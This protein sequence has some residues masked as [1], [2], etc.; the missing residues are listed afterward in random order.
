VKKLIAIVLGCIAASAVYADVGP[1]PGF[2]LIPVTTIVETT[3]DFSDYAFFSI[4]FSTRA[5]LPHAGG[6]KANASHTPSITLHFIPPGTLIKDTGTRRSGSNLYI[7]P[8]S[9]VIERIPGWVRDRAEAAKNSPL[10]PWSTSADDERWFE[11]ARAVRGGEIPGAISV[12]FGST[13][14]VASH[15]PRTEVTIHYRAV[16]GRS[17]ELTLATDADDEIF[18]RA[19]AIPWS[20][21]ISGISV[22]LA[23]ILAGLWLFRRYRRSC[24]IT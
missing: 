15:D 18:S 23:I 4:D 16:R 14:E 6:G 19:D 2:K 3:D 8:A 5:P 22:S 24:T 7:L 17:G 20:W 12:R 9:A 11:L 21:L 13:E 10:Q 1:G